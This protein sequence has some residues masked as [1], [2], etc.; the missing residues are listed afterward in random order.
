MVNFVLCIL[1]HTKKKQWRE[2]SH[3]LHEVSTM[4]TSY[5]TTL[6]YHNQETYMDIIH[7]HYSDFIHL[8]C[9]HLCVLCVCVCV[10][11]LRN[12][13][14]CKHIWSLPHSR[15]RTVPSLPGS[16]MLHFYEDIA[17]STPSSLDPNEKRFW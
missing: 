14:I 3:I 7:Q 4:M 10:C 2:V 6:Q 15:Y 1:Y 17:T 16:F 9:I 12:F 5:I 13:I 11:V 8:T